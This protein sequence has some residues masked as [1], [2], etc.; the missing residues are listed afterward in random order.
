LQ[1]AEERCTPYPENING[2]I[3]SMVWRPFWK[4]NG[5]SGSQWIP[6]FYGTQRFIIVFTGTCH[7]TLTE[8]KRIQAI[9][10]HQISIAAL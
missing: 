2:L 7:W 4:A 10:S 9:S 5:R 3:D 8:A 1:L 6:V